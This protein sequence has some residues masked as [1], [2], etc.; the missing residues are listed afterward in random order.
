MGK[1][2][3]RRAVSCRVIFA[4]T[5]IA[6]AHANGMLH[7]LFDITVTDEAQKRGAEDPVLLADTLLPGGVCLTTGDC[8]QF[9]TKLFHYMN[10]PCEEVIHQEFRAT[11]FHPEMG[12]PV[13]VTAQAASIGLADV[14]A[15]L[16]NDEQSE[17]KGSGSPSP[18]DADAAVKTCVDM[19]NIEL[20]QPTS[21]P[22]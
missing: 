2:R 19:G 20:E 21:L 15:D 13:T 5:A 6:S 3:L 22:A 18:C 11:A 1:G 9:S 10:G 12:C 8:K 14:A 4:T 17:H 16:A 7:Q